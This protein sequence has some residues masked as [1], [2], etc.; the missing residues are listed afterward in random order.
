MWM[1]ITVEYNSTQVDMGHDHGGG[2]L[3]EECYGTFL[4]RVKQ[5]VCDEKRVRANRVLTMIDE[6]YSK[7]DK[8]E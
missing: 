5:M 2:P 7:W 3:R 1:M 6:A 4:M 8:Q